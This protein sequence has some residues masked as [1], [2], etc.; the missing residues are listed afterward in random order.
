MCPH[1]GE[2]GYVFSLQNDGTCYNKNVIMLI[3][4]TCCIKSSDYIVKHVGISRNSLS[5]WLNSLTESD[6]S[7][8]AL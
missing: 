4:I 6:T 5:E 1:G 3:L 8:F 2:Q 7:P